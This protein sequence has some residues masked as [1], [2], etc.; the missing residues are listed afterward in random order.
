MYVCIC[1]AVTEHQI[2][3]AVKTGARTLL[4]LRRDLGVSSECGCC[5]AYAR[6]CLERAKEAQRKAAKSGHSD[7]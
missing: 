2:A 7:A 6:E 3:E 4:D 5:A 1:N